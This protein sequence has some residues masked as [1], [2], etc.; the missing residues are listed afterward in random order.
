M[1]FVPYHLDH[2]HGVMIADYTWWCNNEREILNW[3]AA[4][5]PRG[6]E[7]QQGMTVDF[8]SEQDVLLFMLR[9]QE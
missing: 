2:K 4:H 9:W 7:H 5:L 6:I 1:R 3:M 8:D